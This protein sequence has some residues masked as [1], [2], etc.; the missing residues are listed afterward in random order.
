MSFI[1][2]ALKEIEVDTISSALT[3]MFNDVNG[4]LAMFSHDIGQTPQYFNSSIF[5]A[6]YNITQD[7]IMPIAGLILTFVL[8]YEIVQMVINK[9]NMHDFGTE[10]L[11]RYIM[12]CVISILLVSNAWN[13]ANA[14]F[15]LGQHIVSRTSGS[16]ASSTSLSMT[17][18]VAALETLGIGKLTLLML[19]VMVLRLGMIIM[20]VVVI[21]ILY[22]RMIEMYMHLSVAP[23]PFAT[24]ANREWG[25]IGNSYLKG[26]VALAFQGF[27]MMLCY[28]IYAVLVADTMTGAVTDP[29]TLHT[30][31]LGMMGYTV[32]LCIMLSKCGSISRQV[33]GMM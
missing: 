1:T 26:L 27:F 28:G 13:I 19:E 10:D 30:T 33:M 22:G 25:Q 4:S 3:D 31:L 12:K 32:L 8:G 21:I 11:F 16:I 29:D 15:S 9:N 14:I 24:M 23:I 2:N 17:G 18:V 6:V 5:N 7:V 20:S